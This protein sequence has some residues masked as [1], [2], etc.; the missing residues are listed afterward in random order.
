MISVSKPAASGIDWPGVALSLSLPGCNSCLGRGL[1]YSRTTTTG[2]CRCVLRGVFRVCYREY[3]RLNSAPPLAVVKYERIELSKSGR[4]SY[5][6]SRPNEE[7]CADF[8]LTARR[9]LDKLHFQIFQ[10]WF[11]LGADWK[12]CSAR[13]KLNRGRIFHAVYRI[14]ETLGRAFA[15][16]RP[17]RLYPVDEYMAGRTYN[18]TAP[19]SVVR[20]QAGRQLGRLAFPSVPLLQRAA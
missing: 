7:F 16:T 3:E 5:C 9:T 19:L 12:V 20:A 11:L 18:T 1:V 4:T 2:P 6:F 15:E 8:E 17:Y 10:L 14:E 13:T